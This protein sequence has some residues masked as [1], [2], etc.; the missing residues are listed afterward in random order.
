[1]RPSTI[2]A[3][4]K[5]SHVAKA[6]YLTVANRLGQR[7]QHGDYHLHA[8]PSERRLADE[9]GVSTMTARKAVQKLVDD[10]LLTRQPGGRLHVRRRT[11]PEDGV[12]QLAMLVPAFDSSEVQAWQSVIV[13]TADKHHCSL[14][15]VYYAHW[16]DPT[17]LRTLR[18]FEGVFFLPLS[19]PPPSAVNDELNNAERAIVVLD[20]D[21]SEHN[22]PSLRQFPLSSVHL[23]LDH[24]YEIGCRRIACLNAQPEDPVVLGRIQQWRL[25]MAR[26]RLDGPLV[27]E[28]VQPFSNAITGAYRTATQFVTDH[29]DAVDAVLGITEAAAIG[30]V[31][32]LADRGLQA[33][34]DVAVCAIN[35]QRAAYMVPSV[36]T[37]GRA[38]VSSL[39]GGCV[40][41]MKQLPHRPWIGPL[42]IEP[43]QIELEIRESTRGWQPR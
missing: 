42:M 9:I 14:R 8:L 34:R 25:W 20:Y 7:I 26:H 41:W 17:L 37:L 12:C 3:D 6:K 30:T 4:W 31:R 24:L 13:R 10:G 18:G 15:M 43:A 39:V 21:W 2:R 33:G 38:D 5:D 28:P 19:G 36:T 35:G 32:A 1:M 16:D 11:Q 23:L 27:H 40:Q 29:G 22:T